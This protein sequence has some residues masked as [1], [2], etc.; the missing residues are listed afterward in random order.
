MMKAASGLVFK[1]FRMPKF[2]CSLWPVLHK[3]KLHNFLC[4]RKQGWEKGAKG[5]QSG[6]GK[7]V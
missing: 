3:A 2:P 1:V 4:I 7:Y 5:V 6:M